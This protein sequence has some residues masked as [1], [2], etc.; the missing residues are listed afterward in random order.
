MVVEQRNN[1][2]HKML[3]TFDPK[4]LESCAEFAVAL[5]EQHAQIMPEYEMLQSIVRS[6]RETQE[7]V[8]RYLRSDEFMSELKDAGGD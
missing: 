1:L 4:S 5:D 8:Q 3:L 2:V 7:E 6:F